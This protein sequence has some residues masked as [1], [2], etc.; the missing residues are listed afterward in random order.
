MIYQ[1][2]DTVARITAAQAQKM[3]ENGVRFA[4]RYIGPENWGKTITQAEADT[5]HKNGVSILLCYETGAERMRGGAAAGAADGANALI[6]AQQLGVPAGT[7][8]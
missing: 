6:Y 3:R 8:I 1:G 4:G 5:L 7:A 2:I